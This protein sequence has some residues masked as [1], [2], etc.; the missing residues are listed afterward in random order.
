MVKKYRFTVIIRYI[1]PFVNPDAY[2]FYATCGLG[3]PAK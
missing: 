3:A 2:M 1:R